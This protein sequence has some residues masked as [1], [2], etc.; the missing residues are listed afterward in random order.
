MDIRSQVGNVRI[1]QKFKRGVTGSTN[2]KVTGY[3]NVDVT[4]GGMKKFVDGSRAN[5]LSPFKL[6]PI[7]VNGQKVAE[8]FEN[9]WQ[10]GKMWKLAGHFKQGNIIEPSLAWYAFRKKGYAMTKGKRHPFPKA[11]GY[12]RPGHSMYNDKLYE[13]VPSRK[14][15]YIPL[16]AALIRHLPVMKEMKRLLQNGQN[17]MI[18]DGDGPPQKILVNGQL[19]SLYPTGTPMNIELWNKMVNDPK[20][21]FGHGYVVAALLAG[22]DVAELKFPGERKQTLV[23]KNTMNSKTKVI[24]PKKIIKKVKGSCKLIRFDLNTLRTSEASYKHIPRL[25]APSDPTC[26]LML[27][28]NI[29]KHLHMDTKLFQEVWDVRP[30]LPHVANGHA[31]PRK[32][33]SYMRD[34]RY[35]RNVNKGIE[36]NHSFIKHLLKWVNWYC[37]LFLPSGKM[38]FNEILV[39]WYDT[40]AE[41]IGSHSDETKDLVPNSHILC[42]SY[43]ESRNLRIKSKRTH[44]INGKAST[45]P[46][47]NQVFLT[48]NNTFYIMG[49][50]FQDHL[51]HEISPQTASMKPG[52]R[53][54]VTFRAFKE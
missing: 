20:Y 12:G 54:S 29:P 11:K 48:K 7:Y 40:G 27:C 47:Y 53:I 23:P 17:I 9:Y 13:Y 44:I 43:G 15:I 28:N 5:S 24:L 6:G 33:Q 50:S 34:Y 14:D 10:F 3:L 21:S 25:V 19:Q 51:K 52:K 46:L 37:G 30:P 45:K 36:I 1:G 42:F 22:L 32:Q 8:I 49:G 38:Y 2:P 41:Y 31:T 26:W 4:S 16:Y 39:N 35:S 18:L